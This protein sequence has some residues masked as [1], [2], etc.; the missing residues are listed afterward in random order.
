M[1]PD[2]VLRYADHDEAVIDLHLPDGPDDRVVVLLHGGF[3][4][5][6]W[7]RRHTRP[8]AR[9]L[10]DIGV[11]VATPEYRR[12]G[13]G[14]GWPGTT[15][16]VLLAVRRL[17]EML[18]W[19]GIEPAPLVVTGHSAGGHLALWL[20]TTNLPVQRVVALAP[21]CDLVEAT[22]LGL[23][24][25]AAEAFLD[26]ADPS[27]V[28]PMVLLRN[29]PD[30]EVTVVHGVD[31][32]DVPVSLSRGLVAAHPWV[33]LHALEGTGHMDLIDPGSSAW[34]TVV[35]ALTAGGWSETAR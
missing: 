25:G 35:E 15:D 9:A 18:G 1:L 11:V 7:D 27:A 13:N 3:W 19:V 21:V 10:A 12:V 23:G 6:E 33:R 28:D 31:D 30:A 5:A 24:D 26:G 20:T 16:D 32:A 8:M 22:R 29:R 14:G 2:A 17:P 34:P 4:R